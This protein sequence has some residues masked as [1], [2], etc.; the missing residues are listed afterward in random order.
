MDPVMLALAKEAALASKRYAIM[1][2]AAYFVVDLLSKIPIVGLLFFCVNAFLVLGVYI[3]V[4]YLVTPKLTNLPA[5]Q[6]RTMLGLT[7]G[8]GSAAMLTAAFLVAVLISGILGVIVGA[9]LGGSNSAFGSAVGGTAFLVIRLI[10]TAIGGL[11]VGTLLAF[12]G[13]YLAFERNKNLQ[14]TVRPF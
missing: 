11:I 4:G 8:A 10:F 5:G 1:F 13:S 6:S 2:A 9:G 14:P 3:G 12:L 7:I